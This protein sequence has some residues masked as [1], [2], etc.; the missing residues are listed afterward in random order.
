MRGMAN[1]GTWWK[2]WGFFY[3]KL[4]FIEW[5]KSTYHVLAHGNQGAM[6]EFICG[7]SPAGLLGYQVVHITLLIL[8]NGHT[9]WLDILFLQVKQLAKFVAKE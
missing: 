8:K 5:N 7:L 4:N 6:K 3:F 1:L 2:I 9:P